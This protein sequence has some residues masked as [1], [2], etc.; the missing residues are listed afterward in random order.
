MTRSRNSSFLRNGL[1]LEPGKK[2]GLPCCGVD[3]NAGN[4]HETPDLRY[5]AKNNMSEKLRLFILWTI[6]HASQI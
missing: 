4:K 5:L 1:K 2:G 3:L 6:N